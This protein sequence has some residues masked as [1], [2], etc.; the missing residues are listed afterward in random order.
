[1]S[2]DVLREL[3][4]SFYVA[5]LQR[6]PRL[7]PKPRLN[8]SNRQKFFASFFQKRRLFLPF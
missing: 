2:E 7:L 5:L 3:F 6:S 8:F 4:P 1:M